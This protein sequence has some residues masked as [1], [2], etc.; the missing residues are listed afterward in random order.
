MC[1]H[2]ADRI[3]DTRRTGTSSA[4]PPRSTSSVHHRQNG[5]RRPAVS[6]TPSAPGPAAAEPTW[7]RSPMASHSASRGR[8]VSSASAVACEVPAAPQRR[9][10]VADPGRAATRSARR[11]NSRTSSRTG[12]DAAGPL[13]PTA[14]RQAG[15]PRPRRRAP[16]DRAPRRA[17]SRSRYRG[18]RVTTALSCLH[19]R[20]LQ[21]VLR[22][23][24]RPAVATSWV[25]SRTV[26]RSAC[27]VV[28]TASE[29]I[30]MSLGQD[31]TKCVDVEGRRLLDSVLA[32][33]LGQEASRPSRSARRR[34]RSRTCWTRLRGISTSSQP[35]ADRI[36]R[37]AS[38]TPL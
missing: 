3:V 13:P 4:P 36:R 23:G 35:S 38:V 30:V 2:V 9:M 33:A 21:F 1:V 6:R 27:P 16:A 11:T 18:D 26:S 28:L 5:Q 19:T 22:R 20:S 8:P 25:M 14:A 24:D 7:T 15:A 17:D 31:T 10:H 37:G 12:R 29:Y 32:G 34:R